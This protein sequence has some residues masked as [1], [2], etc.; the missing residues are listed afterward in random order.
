VPQALQMKAGMRAGYRT[1]GLT[2]T[3]NQCNAVKCCRASVH[4]PLSVTCNLYSIL[5][6]P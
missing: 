1:L 2:A 3:P 4:P 5:T 6:K